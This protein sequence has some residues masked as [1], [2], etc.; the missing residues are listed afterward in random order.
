L[1]QWSYKTM[2]LQHITL[3]NSPIHKTI[4]LLWKRTY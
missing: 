4:T 3:A 1:V 2:L